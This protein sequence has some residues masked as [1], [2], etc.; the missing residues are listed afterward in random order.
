MA[1]FDFLTNLKNKM[2]ELFGQQAP[3]TGGT[4]TPLQVS[5]PPTA[6]AQAPV[7]ES[8]PMGAE[9]YGQELAGAA[10]PSVPTV[11]PA[12]GMGGMPSTQTPPGIQFG[13]PT[14]E[15][16]LKLYFSLKV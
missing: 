12:Q 8:P 1:N 13:N 9:N 11:P 2:S 5:S 7:A 4:A 15:E 16:L 14:L 6:E 10:T 3:S